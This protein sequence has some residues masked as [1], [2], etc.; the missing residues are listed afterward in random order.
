[1]S[2]E[3]FL[4]GTTGV[5][6]ANQPSRLS[7]MVRTLVAPDM[8]VESIQEPRDTQAQGLLAMVSGGVGPLVGALVCGWLRDRLVTADGHGWAQ[9][10]GTLA[11][12]IAGCF[13]I[14]ALFYKGLG[15]P[16]RHAEA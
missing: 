16:K 10:W 12:M 14:F 5:A 13:V 2:D 15:K 11:A 9:F 6:V 8:S 3:Q 7:H 4:N 1:M